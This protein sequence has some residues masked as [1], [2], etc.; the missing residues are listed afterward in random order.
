MV[1]WTIDQHTNQVSLLLSSDIGLDFKLI[2]V[3]PA[4]HKSWPLKLSTLYL[5]VHI[6]IQKL[7]KPLEVAPVLH[8]TGTVLGTMSHGQIMVEMFK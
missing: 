2:V 6:G 7:S 4:A 3:D 5:I 1:H 8:N